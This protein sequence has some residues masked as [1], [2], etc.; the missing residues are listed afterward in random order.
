MK[1]DNLVKR[2]LIVVIGVSLICSGVFL[3]RNGVAILNQRVIDAF[4]EA[5]EIELANKNIER[6]ALVVQNRI[7]ISKIG[8]APQIVGITRATG[9]EE[10]IVSAE[11]HQKNVAKDVDTRVLHSY[12]LASNPI[13]IDSLNAIWK[14]ILKD[15][16]L[17]GKT[18]LQMSTMNGSGHAETFMTADS[19]CFASAIPLFICYLGYGCEI[20][21]V[22]FFDYSCW[23]VL[24][25]YVIIYILLILVICI[26]IY[27]FISYLRKRYRYSPAIKE[28]VVTQL[29]RDVP[30]RT[31][32]IYQLKEN[33][34]FD[35]EKRLLIVDGQIKGKLPLQR[36]AL[37]EMLLN[38]E[39]SKLS[40]DAIMKQLWPDRSGT[41]VRLQQVIKRLRHDL[42]VVD[43][44]IDLK[45]VQP[46]SYQLFI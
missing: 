24:G 7:D 8:Q 27:F 11:Q 32:R 18:A 34:I 39:E 23:F 4:S 5:L 45:R 16:Y 6:G 2:L 42:A 17:I 22:G 46:Y 3:Y 10:Y 36:C 25:R 40:D 21:I 13:A 26:L 41:V 33:F 1:R 35:A 19:I 30:K 15:S 20:K 9:R 44:S 31:I 38:A 14:Q 29:V 37:L 28:V 12:I 43:P